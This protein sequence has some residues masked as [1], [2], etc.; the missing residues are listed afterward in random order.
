MVEKFFSRLTAEKVNCSIF[1][2]V[3]NVETQVSTTL[4]N[5]TLHF[6]RGPQ[7]EESYKF[8]ITDKDPIFDINTT[9]RRESGFYRAKEG[10]FQKKLC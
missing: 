7:K 6:V 2:C 3:H 5:A 8:K 10:G 9:F 1:L 4:R